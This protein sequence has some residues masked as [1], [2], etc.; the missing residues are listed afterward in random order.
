MGYIGNYPVRFREHDLR[1]LFTENGVTVTTIRLKHDGHKVFAFAETTS[2]E[3]I[4]KAIK[5]LDSKEIHGRRLR[6]RSSKDKDGKGTGTAERKRPPP[7]RKLTEDD[8]TRH[9]VFAFNGF[10][11]RQ[12]NKESIDEAKKKQIEDAKTM[13]KEAFDIPDDESLKISRNLELI[14]LHNN[15]REIPVPVEETKDENLKKDVK[16]ADEKN[17]D[18]NG[19]ET[20]D[21]DDAENLVEDETNTEEANEETEAN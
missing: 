5:A 3:E 21:G 2:E 10:L 4:Q 11:D 7:K 6:V 18:E 8:V 1:N 13:L 15:R 19:E 20:K 16:E 12:A 17:E 14:F 9:L